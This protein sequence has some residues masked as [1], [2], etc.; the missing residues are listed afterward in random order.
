MKTDVTNDS[1]NWIDT[2]FN[3]IEDA[4]KLRP[5]C[6]LIPLSITAPALGHISVD[7][8]ELS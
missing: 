8:V 3:V 5:P 2:P 4:S 6:S 7:K 1:D